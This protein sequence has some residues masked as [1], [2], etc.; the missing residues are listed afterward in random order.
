MTFL[1]NVGN[2]VPF[3]NS[4]HGTRAQ[5]MGALLSWITSLEILDVG[6]SVDMRNRSHISSFIQKTGALGFIMNLA[7]EEADLTI[8]RSED[9]FACTTLDG[10]KDF[11]IEKVATLAVFKAV[12]SL[13]TLV[14]SWYN[15]DCP[16][17]LRQKL[18]AFV[19]TVVAPATLQRE[20]V[21]IKGATSFDEMS[22][23]GSCVSREI[24]ATYQQDEV[25][26]NILIV[27]LC[28]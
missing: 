18:S 22:V 5:L 8:S 15:D 12:E 26:A 25:R 6:G 21:R 10:E 27:Y 7:S 4:G 24:I 20:L 14:K 9:I 28:N 3:A 11:T 13:P 1:Q 16:R 2:E 17:F 19:E 23:S